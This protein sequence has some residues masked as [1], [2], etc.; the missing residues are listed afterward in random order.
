MTSVGGIP[1]PRSV[2]PSSFT[3][4]FPFPFSRPLLSSFFFSYVKPLINNSRLTYSPRPLVVLSPPILLLP[5]IHLFSPTHPSPP[6]TSPPFLSSLLLLFS[7]RSV[8]VP[9]VT[10][11]LFGNGV[12]VPNR[13]DRPD[14]VSDERGPGQ[15]MGNNGAPTVSKVCQEIIRSRLGPL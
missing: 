5:Y 1:L 10:I 15:K 14:S 9:P 8:R 6:P 2:R 4:P 3:F 13:R 12:G 11:L 7:F